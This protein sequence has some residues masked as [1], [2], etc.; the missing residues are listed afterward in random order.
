MLFSYSLKKLNHNEK[1]KF[2]YSLIGRN[3]EG[4]VKKVKGE[5][6]GKGAVIVPIENGLIFEEFLEKWKL[7]YKRKNIL[8][9]SI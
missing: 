6:L 5:S 3:S 7:D 1:T 9:S 4:I 8:V 2:T